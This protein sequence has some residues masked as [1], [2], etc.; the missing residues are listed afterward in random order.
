MDEVPRVPKSAFQD[1]KDAEISDIDSDSSNSFD[2]E[3]I[4]KKAEGSSPVSFRRSTSDGMKYQ[5]VE[6]S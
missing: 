1:L 5:K 2:R 3:F 4:H 6:V